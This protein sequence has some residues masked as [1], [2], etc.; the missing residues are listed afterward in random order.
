MLNEIFCPTFDEYK[1]V[2]QAAEKNIELLL[3]VV[4]LFEPFYTFLL[5]HYKYS[6]LYHLDCIKCD[7]YIDKLVISLR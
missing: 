4:V 2:L 1:I 6:D 7:V 5:L 3:L